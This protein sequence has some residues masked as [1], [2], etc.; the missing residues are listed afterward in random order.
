MQFYA[1]HYFWGVSAKTIILVNL[2]R[3][4]T[5]NVERGNRSQRRNKDFET[6]KPRLDPTYLKDKDKN[7]HRLAVAFPLSPP[8]KQAS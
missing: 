3:Q 1:I 4:N 8:S 2:G 7:V 5:Q 6:L